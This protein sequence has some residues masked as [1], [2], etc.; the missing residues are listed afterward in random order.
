MLKLAK[1]ECKDCRVSSGSRFRQVEMR[2]LPSKFSTGSY[3]SYRQLKHKMDEET[4]VLRRW[5][6][7][8]QSKLTELV[9]LTTVKKFERRFERQ[10]FIRGLVN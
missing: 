5:G 2:S 9:N 4:V 6:S 8:T 1:L 10:P 3:L 7:E